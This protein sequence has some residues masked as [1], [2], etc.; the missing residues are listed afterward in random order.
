M[1][2]LLREIELQITD[3]RT[4]VAK[5]NIGVIREIGDGV[6]KVEGLDDAMLNEMLD[7]GKGITGLALDLEETEIG[8]IVLGDSPAR[9]SLQSTNSSARCWAAH[10]TTKLRTLTGRSPLITS[11]VRI[12]TDALRPAYRA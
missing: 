2:D 4:S 11:S 3:A 10:S 7:F 1:A 9:M 5:Q 8:A 12:S 6:A